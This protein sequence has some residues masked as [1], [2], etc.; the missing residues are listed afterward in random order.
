M[1]RHRMCSSSL[2]YFQRDDINLAARKIMP[3]AS[4]VARLNVYNTCVY[5]NHRPASE[6]R[7]A[8]RPMVSRF[9]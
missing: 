8:G 5:A 2:L 9:V 4:C 7:F 1:A 6:W 3:V